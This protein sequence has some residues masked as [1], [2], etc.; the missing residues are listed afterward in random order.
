MSVGII[1]LGHPEAE[2]LR[3]LSRGVSGVLGR[4]V[5]V[6][7]ELPDPDYALNRKRN[8]YSAEG[9]LYT[10]VKGKGHQPYERT[11][12]V[13][14]FDLYA[15][16]LNF[17]FG[18]AF[19]NGALVSMTRLR[20][21]F[22][23]EKT[24]YPLFRKRLLTEAVHELGH[25]YGL[26]HCADPLCVMFFSNSLSDTDRKGFAPCDRCGKRL[27]PSRLPQTSRDEVALSLAPAFAFG[28]GL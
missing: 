4:E 25:T 2:A 26:G 23:G 18:A 27:I 16:E 14:D 6:G 22:Y 1:P 24:D 7:R 21:E 15:P 20:P 11:L 3:E 10:M 17:L 5:I 28:P 13:V 8:Q 19:G 9:I 12:W